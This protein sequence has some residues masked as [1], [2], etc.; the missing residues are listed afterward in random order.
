MEKDPQCGPVY[1][2]DSVCKTDGDRNFMQTAGRPH[3]KGEQ[4]SRSNQEVDFSNFDIVKATQYGAITRV[5]ELIEAGF[6][7]NQRDSENVTLL[8]WAAINNRKEIV[9]YFLSKNAEIDAIGGDLKSTPLHWAT[10][11]GHLQMV[12]LLLQHGADPSVFDGEGCNC[13]HLASQFGHTSIVANDPIR[14]LITLGAS[15]NLTDHKH[16]NTALHWAVYSRNNNAVSLLL[17]AG[18]NV[19]ICNRQGD[20]PL[21]MAKR[22]KIHWIGSRIEETIKDK[23][24]SKKHFCVRMFRDKKIRY[25]CTIGAPFFIYY[26]VGSILHS[27]LS[28]PIKLGFLLLILFTITFGN[29]YIFDERSF[30]VLPMAIYLA[31][32]FWIFLKT[33]RTDPGRIVGDQETKFRTI[34]ELAEKEGFEPSVFCTTCLI[35]R[36]IRSKHCSICNKCIARFDHHC[37]WVGNCV[38]AQNHKYFV[39]YLISLVLM[40]SWFLIGSYL[41]WKS[42]LSHI[43]SHPFILKAIQINGWV[44]L[45]VINAILHI[46][47]V[48]CLLICQLYQIIWLSM[49]T[50]ERMNCRRY[51]HFKRDG[52]VVSPFDHGIIRNL[53]EFCEW[54]CIQAYKSDI[55]D[56]RY[57]YDL[58]DYE[59]QINSS[60]T[61]VY[62][63]V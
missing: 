13:L 6:D 12:V 40:C 37:P 47:W 2:P 43:D 49:T 38:G 57:V 16:G 33:W 25:W 4:S 30:N 3:T 54:K 60:Q 39:W 52:H 35:R 28:Y 8:H 42:S 48:G 5:Q 34:I 46:V 31:T 56:W 11:Q 26:F 9:K 14:L 41:Y 22:L 53:L 63:Y 55:R 59:K 10:R 32:K 44:S 21:D 18:A 27:E 50:N 17:N 7:V 45:G 15:L 1:F 62:H 61:K 36:P 51:P 24:L 23:E 58:E 29:H 19:F 20:T